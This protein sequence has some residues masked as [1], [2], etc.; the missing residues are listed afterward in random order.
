ME[1]LERDSLVHKLDILLS[2]ALVGQGQVALVSGEAGIGKTSLV[3]HFTNAHEGSVRVLWGA[4]EVLFTPRPLG[5]L[6]D[7]AIDVGGELPMLLNSNGER[8]A[9]FSM[10][11]AEL[12]NRPTIL[13]F[14][15]VHWADEATLDL[16]KLLGRRIQRL[17]ALLVLS[18][19][20]DIASLATLRP[21]FAQ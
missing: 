18:H 7:F 8:Q 14:E 1:L 3:E 10:C 21:V 11:F 4:C 15:D 20:D 16:I 6:H 19:R 2:K 5:P 9:I 13:V 12:Q 17:P